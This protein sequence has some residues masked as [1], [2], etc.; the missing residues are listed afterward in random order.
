MTDLRAWLDGH[1]GREPQ[2]GERTRAGFHALCTLLGDPQDAFPAIL[3]GGTV[4]K[5]STT[6]LTSALLYAVGLS[7]G[8]F[9]SPHL[10]RVNERI[11]WNGK[12]IADV[13]LDARLRQIA[14]IEPYL[15]ESPSWFEI[16]TA[17]ALA[18]FSDVAVQVGVI[19]VGLGGAGDATACVRSEVVTLTNIGIDHTAN[20]GSTYED[21]AMAESGIITEDARVVCGEPDPDLVALMRQRPH[22]QWWQFGEEFDL[23][24][25]EIAVGGRVVHITTPEGDYPD[26]FLGLHG[27]HQGRNATVALATAEAFLGRPIERDIVEEVFATARVPGRLEVLG[28][29]PLVVLD[30][31]H[32]LPGAHALAEALDDTFPDAP[33]RWVLGFLQQKNPIEMLDALDVRTDDVVYVA[34][35]VTPR[36][37]DPGEVAAAVR[38]RGIDD[39]TVIENPAVAA[40]RAVADADPEDLVIVTGSLYLLG[41]ARPALVSGAV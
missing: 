32:N 18:E 31:A 10:E 6:M 2:T 14:D 25:D 5:T 21:I 24:S 7:T 29:Q 38:A 9:T 26:V 36:A 12:P 28:H 41:A 37:I 23:I 13:D 16:V 34:R 30:A 15:P 35:P 4:G 3:V 40:K 11:R 39:V 27:R 33:R 17:A 1:I 8:T 22:A 20:F 19:E